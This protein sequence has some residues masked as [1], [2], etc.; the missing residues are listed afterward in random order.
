LT[1]WQSLY[2]EPGSELENV[3][4]ED[5][6]VRDL[7]KRI[8][9]SGMLEITE[10]KEGLFLRASSYVGRIDLGNLRI[11]ITPKVEGKALLRLLRYAYG[12]RDLGLFSGVGYEAEPEA[13]QDLLIHQ[14]AAEA[15]ELLSRGLHRRYVR[16]ARDLSSP[17]G[18]IDM[19][20][21]AGRGGITSAELPCVYHTRLE[22]NVFNRVLLGGLRLSTR[23]TGDLR[24]RSVLRRLASML[25]E[26]VS[27]VGLS[28][29]ALRTLRRE[30]S[31]LTVA[32]DPAITIIEILFGSEGISLDERQP[33][34][35][36]PGFLFDMN[37][38]FQA[39]VSRILNENLPGYSVRDE[40]RLKGMMTYLPGYNPRNRKD[41]APRPDFVVLKGLG[42]VSVLDAKYRDLWDKPLPRE[43]LYQLAI[44]AL[45]QGFGGVATI[46]YPTAGEAN[47]QEARIEMRDTLYGLGRAQVILR[48]VN[49]PYLEK[50]LSGANALAANEELGRYA[51][52]L[53]F[54]GA[55]LAAEEA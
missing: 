23:L 22:D 44:Y 8:T 28:R 14:L 3:F 49:L 7:A 4:L 43:M 33:R 45:S 11:T 53:A 34:I 55:N 16:V 40:H 24:L 41:P 2:P 18:K 42:V 5:A 36:L 37:L 10:L 39:L 51:R 54:G 29:E 12:L 26:G 32:Y 13:F 46:L 17:R 1:E 21:I 19:R 6:G 15:Q 47:L 9:R 31:R 52:Q 27:E 50:L 48:S 25:G 35:R 20:T 30:R 38:F